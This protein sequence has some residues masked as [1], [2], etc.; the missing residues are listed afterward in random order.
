MIRGYIR[1]AAV[2]LAISCL[3][4]G[5]CDSSSVSGDSLDRHLDAGVRAL[6]G[7]PQNQGQAFDVFLRAVVKSAS[8]ELDDLE[9][10]EPPAPAHRGTA[11]RILRRYVVARYGEAMVADLQEMIAFRTFHEEGRDNWD[12]PEFL[13]QRRWLAERAERLGLEFR[14]VDGRVDEIEHVA[15]DRVLG[16]LTHGDVQDVAGQTWSVPPWEGRL[17][18]GRILGRGSEDDKGPI[19]TAIYVFA[20]LRESGWLNGHTLR[21]MI[22]NGEECCWDEIPYY[23]ERRSPPDVTIGFDAS[24]PVTH[25]QKAWGVLDLS[26]PRPK[27]RFR[28]DGWHIDSVSGGSGLS[29][30]P[31]RAE[32]LLR[33]PRDGQADSVAA[34]ADR[35]RVWAEDHPPARLEVTVED[36]GRVRLTAYGR[37]GHSSIPSSGHNAFGDLTRFVYESFPDEKFSPVDWSVLLLCTG[38]LIGTE[39]DGHS[40]GIAYRDDVMGPL[41]TNLALFDEVDGNPR[42][43][44]NLRIPR[45]IETDAIESAVEESVKQCR[46]LYGTAFDTALRVPSPPHFVEPEGPLVRTLL[47]VWQEVTGEPGVPVAIGGGTQARLFPDGV[48]FGP[49]LTMEGYRGHGPDEYITVDEMHRNAELTIAAVWELS[50]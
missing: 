23:L 34:L 1:F 22:A 24:Y 29:I 27:T 41:T 25:A 31:D 39:T 7:Y 19:V 37:G 10:G 26:V 17:E 32:L 14:T 9:P 47:D 3:I 28:L 13:R 21:L 48:D 4:S 42:A 33:A 43:R 11:S 44:I 16:I 50:R 38:L 49:A 20:A 40:L 45:G 6:A 2:L 15:G 35:A 12:A 5:G 18:D 8:P 46:A 36:D 30:I